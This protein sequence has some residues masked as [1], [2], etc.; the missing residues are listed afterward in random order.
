LYGAAFYFDNAA[1]YQWRDDKKVGFCDL[2]DVD[3][4]QQL[5]SLFWALQ[6]NIFIAC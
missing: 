3:K 6:L 1:G 5:F 2:S 4:E